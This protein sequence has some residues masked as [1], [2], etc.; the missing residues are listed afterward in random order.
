M[1]ADKITA[2]HAK[3]QWTKPNI[4]PQTNKLQHKHNITPQAK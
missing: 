1:Y 3:K 2:E 4:S